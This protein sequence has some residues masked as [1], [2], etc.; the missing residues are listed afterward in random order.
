MGFKTVL[1]ILNALAIESR[2]DAI[3]HVAVVGD[4]RVFEGTPYGGDV[5]ALAILVGKFV[6]G[7]YLYGESVVVAAFEGLE[8]FLC[9]AGDID[10]DACCL[11]LNGELDIGTDSCIVILHLEI[12]LEV[13]HK[14][15]RLDAL[16]C[17]VDAYGKEHL[18]VLSLLDMQGC[19]DLA[20]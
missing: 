13:A 9:H 19:L 18:H 7:V 3:L 17:I 6:V 1:L 14:S 16:Y 12:F 15:C 10:C 2:C 8:Q 20:P 11:T 4:G 5:V